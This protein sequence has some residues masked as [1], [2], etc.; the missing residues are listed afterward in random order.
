MLLRVK[1]GV[2]SAQD[3]RDMGAGEPRYGLVLKTVNEV[4]SRPDEDLPIGG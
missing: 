4:Y 1:D 3:S 2:D